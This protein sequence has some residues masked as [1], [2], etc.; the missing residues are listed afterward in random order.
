MNITTNH[1]GLRAAVLAAC[2][3]AGTA[4]LQPASALGFGWN[5]GDSVQGSGTV[6]RQAREVGHF[7]GLAL[8][9]PGTVELKIGNSEGVTVETDDNLQPLVET[10]VEGET[11]KIRPS[12]RNLNLRIHS[13]KV[14]VQARSIERLALAGSGT[15]NADALRAPRMKF[16]IGGSGAIN[17]RNLDSDAVAATIGGSGDLKAGGNARQLSVSIAGSGNA[18]LG[19][20][21][22]VNASV[23]VAGSGEATVWA[24]GTLNTTIAGSGDVSYYGDP[25]VNR[26]VLGSGEV[27]RL[28]AAPH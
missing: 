15:I 7:T 14:V 18:E 12:R 20:L 4:P 6:T 8:A 17:V 27:H 1:K 3:L 19:Q 10:V 16:D 26:S 24:T 9:L 23:Q 2:V 25:V 28:G 5:G 11:L 21:K 22:A 13:L